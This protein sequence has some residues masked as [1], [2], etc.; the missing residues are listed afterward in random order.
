MKHHMRCTAWVSLGL[1]LAASAAHSQCPLNYGQIG[2]LQNCANPQSTAPIFS[3]SGSECINGG[4]S[5]SY[6]LVAGTLEVTSY[7]YSHEGFETW[8]QTQDDFVIE[9]PRH[10]NGVTVRL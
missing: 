10:R 5:V 7:S 2:Y 6:D 9:R 4:G 1:V 3:M 8:L